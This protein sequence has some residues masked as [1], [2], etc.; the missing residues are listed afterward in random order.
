MLLKVVVKKY[1]GYVPM[2]MNIY[3]A[4][5]AE[6]PVRQDAPIAPEEKFLRLIT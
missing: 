4:S 6:Q 5:A 3:H 1:G 2:N